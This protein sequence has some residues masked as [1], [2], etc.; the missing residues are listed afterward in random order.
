MQPPGD[1]MD[2]PLARPDLPTQEIS[3]Y[4]TWLWLGAFASGG[5]FWFAV[6]LGVHALLS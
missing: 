3:P 6:G 2:P 5:A 4:R 1:T